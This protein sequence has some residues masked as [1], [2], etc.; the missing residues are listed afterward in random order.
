L[1]RDLPADQGLPVSDA[2]TVSDAFSKRKQHLVSRGN[3]Y[4]RED[5]EQNPT[6][7]A[8]PMHRLSVR[9]R[10]VVFICG[11]L[12][13]GVGCGTTLALQP[14]SKT[15]AAAGIVKLSRD[16]QGNTQL[17]LSVN[18]LPEPF[19]LNRALTTFVV[20]SIADDGSRVRNMGQ[21]QL[22]SHRHGVVNLV[23]P[24]TSFK[25]LVTAEESAT[26]EKPSDYAVLSGNVQMNP[27]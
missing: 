23:T 14:G 27:S 2:P 17:A 3:R 8:P 20:W 21:M 15:P 18:Y 24:L 26:A 5:P 6:K 11:A 22:D 25:L 12:A 9:S 13:L 4:N 10:L 7:E 1:S 19:E 16:S